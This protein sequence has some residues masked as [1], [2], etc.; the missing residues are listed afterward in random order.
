MLNGIFFGRWTAK[1]AVSKILERLDR[2]RTEHLVVLLV[3]VFGFAF[4]LWIFSRNWLITGIDGPYYLIQV[5]ALLTRGSLVYGDPPLAFLLLSL[6]CII[7]GDLMLG[8]KVGVSLLCASSAIPAF[9]L[10]KRVGKRSLPGFIAMLLLVFSAPYIRMMTDFMK[11]AIGILFLLSFLYYLHDLAFSGFR[12]KSLILAIFFLILTGLTHI[13]DFGVA[14]L[15][16]VL[17]TLWAV[18]LNVNRGPFLKSAGIIA[19]ALCLFVLVASTFFSPLFTDF[20]KAL[21]FLRDLAGPE[22]AKRPPPRWGL[23]PK[24]FAPSAPSAPFS[25]RVVGGWGPILVILSSGAILSI[26]SW[27]K[28]DKE[29]VLLLA[30]T[31]SMGAIICFPLIPPNWLGRFM[32]MTVV[33]TAIIVSYG[34]SEISKRM[35]RTRG[36][37]LSDASTAL[38]MIFLAVSVLQAA[39]AAS[40]VHP[41]I[42]YEGYLDLVDMKSRIP[43]DSVVVAD[44]PV[45]YWV[46]YVDEVDVEKPTPEIWS[47]HQ[48]VLG[49]FFK[50][51]IPP[52]YSRV[53]YKGRVFVLVELRPIQPPKR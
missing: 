50:D 46:E 25:L 3:F 31:T 42:S 21:S 45:G 29:A 9:Y 17:Y 33:P 26:Y 16:L 49:V 34:L 11:N 53:I 35:N 39:E 52:V 28:K 24:P 14:I 15:F 8:V 40:K 4:N 12:G 43:P 38:I 36:N 32:L 37:P 47:T 10:M 48:R 6:F 7:T 2:N 19:L 23:K 30:A 20:S 44:F 51:R 22:E 5:R 1:L 27:L 41:T 18:I 13:L